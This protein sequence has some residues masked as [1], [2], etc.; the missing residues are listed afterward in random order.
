MTTRTLML[1]KGGRKYIFRYA[2][3]GEAR[4]IDEIIRLAE[5][6]GEPL[7]WVDAAMLSFQVAQY[8]AED[9]DNVLRPTEE[10]QV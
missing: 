10:S 7:D 3:G 5:E 4:V 9:C 8:A 1:A 6:G 2:G